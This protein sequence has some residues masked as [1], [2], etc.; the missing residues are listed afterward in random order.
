MT[1]MSADQP[2]WPGAWDR[3][4]AAIETHI[5]VLVF[6]GDRVYKALKPVRT[7]FLDHST[8]A[9]RRRAAEAELALNRRLAPDVY[10]GLLEVDD[11]AGPTEPVIAMRRMPTDRRLAALVAAGDGADCVRAVAR[12]LAAFHAAAPGTA[13][14]RAAATPGAVWE[15]W[16]DNAAGLRQ[17]G[18]GIV[19]A[20]ALADA[21]LRAREYV[22]GRA[23]LFEARI[24]AG[25]I[26]DGHGDVLADDIFCL[27]DGPRILDCLAF[28]DRLRHGDV[29]ADV[30]FLAMDLERLGR[31]DLAG[32]LLDWYREFSFERHPA[33]LAHYYVAYRAQIRAKVACLRAAQGGEGAAEEAR[34][35]LEISLGRLRRA[36][37]RLVLVGGP[38]GSGKSALSR[39]L[40]RQTG[41]TLLRSDELRKDLA[42]LAHDAS[43]RAPL[44]EGIYR[45]DM[46][47]AVYEELGRR[48]ERLL[49]LGESVILD[50]S[51]GSEPARERARRLAA[52]AR[53]RVV[54]LRCEAPAA[55]ADQRVVARSGGERAGS[56]ATLEVARA[57]RASFDAWPSATT[58][59]TAGTVAAAASAGAEAFGAH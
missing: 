48:A 37:V 46:T 23:A 14:I 59:D 1:G 39:A 29:L 43:G 50:A 52:S 10:L 49:E 41:A 31:A 36:E 28:D 6:V 42:G 15:L 40:S 22:L 51:W 3:P 7:G 24:A 33:S 58:V 21:D 56:D 47:E 55:L 38:P 16:R 54:E 32:R 53:A 8:A 2:M 4:V 30:G 44:G 5:S 25:R 45:A 20:E 11:G 26:R 27:P 13:A 19:D 17:A 12:T 9:A 35:L 34:R 57:M 18:R